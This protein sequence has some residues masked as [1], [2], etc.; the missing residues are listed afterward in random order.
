MK[1]R[2]RVKL[3]DF[4]VQRVVAVSDIGYLGECFTEF[5][6]Q[7]ISLCLLNLVPWNLRSWGDD[8]TRYVTKLLNANRIDELQNQ[9]ETCVQFEMRS[10]FIFT[11]NLCTKEFDY[12]DKIT[13]RGI[14][15][16][17][18]MEDFLSRLKRK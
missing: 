1:V 6:I 5:P 15:R 9:Y 16:K 14:A 10:N 3:V 2:V 12:A 4:G 13:S 7:S 11:S 8:D 18:L 17:N